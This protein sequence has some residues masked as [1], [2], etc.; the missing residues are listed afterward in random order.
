MQK[1]TFSADIITVYSSLQSAEIFVSIALP[2][3]FPCVYSKYEVKNALNNF[4][5]VALAKRRPPASY[6]TLTAGFNGILSTII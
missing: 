2:L 5:W 3:P 1:K 6:F 4:L